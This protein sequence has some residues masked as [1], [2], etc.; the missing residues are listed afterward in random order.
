M[1]LTA[2]GALVARFYLGTSL[3]GENKTLKRV[4][5]GTSEGWC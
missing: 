5:Q 4:V 3:V 1:E 2:S